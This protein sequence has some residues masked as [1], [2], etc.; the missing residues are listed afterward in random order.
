MKVRKVFSL[1]VTAPEKEKKPVIFLK[2]KK[3]KCSAKNCSCCRK[4]DFDQGMLG[5]TAF[6]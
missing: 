3:Q 2:S 4:K 5:E 1:Q 6:G